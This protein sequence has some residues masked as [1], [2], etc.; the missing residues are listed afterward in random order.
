MDN[1]IFG[2]AYYEEYLPYDRLDQDM[3]MM[4]AAGMN[5]I[6]I[7]ESTWSVEEPRPGEYDFHHID[8]VIDAASHYGLQVI[9]GTPTYA[10]PHWMVQEDPTV[11]A[12]TENGA[13]QY[14]T[15]QNMDITNSTYRAYAEKIITAL[16]QHTAKHSHVIGYQIDN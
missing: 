7:A 2:A 9:V 3:K 8:R 15:R 6:R 1:L 4:V 10:V 14:G 11:L 13:S 16:V 12:I 5:T